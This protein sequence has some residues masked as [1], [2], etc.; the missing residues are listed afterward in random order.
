MLYVRQKRKA[1]AIL[2]AFV[3]LLVLIFLDQ[4]TKWFALIYLKGE[5]AVPLIKDVFELSYVENYGAA[6]GILQNNRILLAV[7]AG[8]IVIILIGVYF[9]LPTYQKF[10]SMRLLL[11]IL[12]AG[13]IGNMIDRIRLGYVIDFLYFRL[14]DFPVFNI[15]DIYVT[16]SIAVILF[17]IFFFYNDQD[18]DN[19]FHTDK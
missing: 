3:E 1:S 16:C 6:F 15:A 9:F 7:F 19:I 5:K 11:V 4:A 18:M 17:Q 13:T 12:L 2:L 8:M 10:S 14:I